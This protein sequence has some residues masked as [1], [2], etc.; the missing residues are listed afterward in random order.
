MYSVLLL[1]DFNET[2]I[3]STESRKLI[4]NFMAFIIVGDRFFHVDKKMTTGGLTIKTH[5]I[6]VRK[7]MLRNLIAEF[8]LRIPIFK[9]G[10]NFSS[11]KKENH[12]GRKSVEYYG[13]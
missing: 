2:L 8:W 1:L 12:V 7:N 11:N 6:Y 13:I 10:I 5:S 3:F 9:T 4:K